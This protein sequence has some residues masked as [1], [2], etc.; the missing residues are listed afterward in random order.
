MARRHY[1][2][3]VTAK[4][5]D[6]TILNSDL[7]CIFTNRGASGTVIF[8][9]PANSASVQGARVE[10]YTVAAQVITI[11]SNPADTLVVHAD[12]AAD[13]ISSAATIGQHFK[14]IFDGTAW[15]VVSNPSAATTATAVTAV[16]IA[17]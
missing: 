17:T 2:E 6:Y 13:T 16:T 14:C 3:T 9:L 4:T 5:S 8:T 11:T 1:P 7:P 15:L 10:F 12:A